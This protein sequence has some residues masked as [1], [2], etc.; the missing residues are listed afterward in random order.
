MPNI[1]DISVP[2]QSGIPVWPGSPGFRLFQT[3]RIDAGEVANVSKLETD[4]NIGT[5]C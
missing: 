5:H 3:M 4:V 1:I 2:L